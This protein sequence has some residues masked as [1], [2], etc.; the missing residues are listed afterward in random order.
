MKKYCFDT[1]GFSTPVE[2]MPDDIFGGLWRK[3]VPI[4]EAGEIAVTT[5]IYDE[6]HG[7]IRSLIG[8][9]IDTNRVNMV[10]EIGDER[11]N[12]SAYTQTLVQ[13]R[14]RH[15]A[16]ISEYTGGSPRTVGLVDISIIAL[17]KAIGVP[18]VTEER[19]VSAN[20]TAKRKIPDVCNLE[21]VECLTF[22]DFLRRSGI[23]MA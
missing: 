19:P 11:W 2:R 9:C 20:T 5:E 10:L 12:Y 8:N 13:I 14:E 18:V 22:N 21:G 3:V 7:S 23:N 1:S 17:A 16:F 15:K 4:I 6:M